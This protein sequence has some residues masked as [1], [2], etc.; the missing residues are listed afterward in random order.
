MSDSAIGSAVLSAY[1]GINRNGEKH[2]LQDQDFEGSRKSVFYALHEGKALFLER[3]PPTLIAS[4]FPHTT[5][6]FD[7]KCR[8]A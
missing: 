4:F 1:T 5:G 7:Q 6:L 2:R 3:S 8:A